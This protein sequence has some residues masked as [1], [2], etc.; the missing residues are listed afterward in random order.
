VGYLNQ[1]LKKSDNEI[2]RY[3]L[4]LEQTRADA[5]SLEMK[6]SQEQKV[7]L[8]NMKKSCK[9]KLRSQLEQLDAINKENLLQRVH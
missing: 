7:A 5:V 2:D 3:R 6:M 9:E 4:S 8:K 1:I